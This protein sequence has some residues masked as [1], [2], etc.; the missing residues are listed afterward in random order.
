MEYNFTDTINEIYVIYKE[1]IKTYIEIGAYILF[2]L[3]FSLITFLFFKNTFLDNFGSIL[4]VFTTVLSIVISTT[5]IVIQL[6]S[7]KYGSEIWKLYFKEYYIKFYLYVLPISLILGILLVFWYS[8]N[9]YIDFLDIKIYST[10]FSFNERWI[11]KENPFLILL[12]LFESF[13]I[14]FSI[15]L[16]PKYFYNL[17]KTLEPSTVLKMVLKQVTGKEIKS[18]SKTEF[19]KVDY[20]ETYSLG[21]LAKVLHYL[22][23]NKQY[24]AVAKCFTIIS[25]EFKG[26]VRIYKLN[27]GF[28]EFIEDYIEIIK[29]IAL[30]EIHLLKKIKSSSIN[31]LKE[32][33]IILNSNNLSNEKSN[34]AIGFII[35]TYA[36]K[37]V[38]CLSGN[39][40]KKAINLVV[41]IG[42]NA[43][44][45]I[46]KNNIEGT[47]ENQVKNIE[48]MINL[49]FSTLSG[50]MDILIRFYR[51]QGLAPNNRDIIAMGIDKAFDS[52]SKLTKLF[53]EHFENANTEYL[54]LLRILISEYENIVSEIGT[55][56]YNYEINNN[57]IFKEQFK[58]FKEPLEDLK[59][60]ANA[61]GNLTERD[62]I[63]EIIDKINN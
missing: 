61:K 4:G 29:E 42:L 33:S 7:D 63:N 51:T 2:S 57:Y 54:G 21:I 27:E 18:Y 13:L 31:A 40:F 47:L 58:R 52:I 46:T 6:A 9:I 44:L 16:V 28:N 56:Y 48:N 32:I 41:N 5:F 14:F 39:K 59:N 45:E 15:C 19:S 30:K 8:S 25:N 17:M 20:I 62:R 26:L 36:E 53:T 24:M 38:N 60:K 55:D 49:N 50:L 1:K 23:E 34:E 37:N 12:G 43:F 11:F 3:M 35:L 22:I 10:S